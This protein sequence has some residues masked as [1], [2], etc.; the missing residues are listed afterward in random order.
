MTIVLTLSRTVLAVAETFLV[1]YIP[2]KLKKAMVNMVRTNQV[3][4][5][6]LLPN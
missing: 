3:R 4:R 5:A 2:E 6:E 1:T